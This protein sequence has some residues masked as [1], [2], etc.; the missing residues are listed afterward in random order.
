MEY[1]RSVGKVIEGQL[2][3]TIRR[4]GQEMD[5]H[6]SNGDSEAAQQSVLMAAEAIN[7]SRAIVGHFESIQAQLAQ[8][9]LVLDPVVTHQAVANRLG[10]ADS[11]AS[12]THLPVT[13][14]N[15]YIPTKSVAPASNLSTQNQ[16]LDE[17]ATSGIS[18]AFNKTSVTDPQV[19]SDP[20]I[21]DM[22]ERVIPAGVRRAEIE[23]SRV[24]GDIGRVRALL[25]AESLAINPDSS[26]YL[27][28]RI[29]DILK[30]MYHEEL[31]SADPKLI[32]KLRPR[33]YVTRPLAVKDL[34][35]FLQEPFD[36]ELK[37]AA[38][39]VKWIR[40]QPE[41][42]S[43]SV[44]EFEE[45]FKRNI[46]FQEVARIARSRQASGS[47]GNTTG[48][49]DEQKAGV[50]FGDE[51]IDD[52]EQTPPAPRRP[53]VY[54]DRDGRTFIAERGDMAKVQSSV[55]AELLAINGI[56][57][58][59]LHESVRDAVVASVRERLVGEDES[60]VKSEIETTVLQLYNIRA[61]GL[62]KLRNWEKM[63]VAAPRYARTIWAWIREQPEYK[64]LS[65]DELKQ[66]LTRE[67]SY[68]DLRRRLEADKI[69]KASVSHTQLGLLVREASVNEP[70]GVLEAV[71][72][73]ELNIP[74]F[75]G[76]H[77][78][79]IA[80]ALRTNKSTLDSFGLKLND[81]DET[82][83]Q[84][85]MTEFLSDSQLSTNLPEAAEQLPE[86]MRAFYKDPEAVYSAI[87]NSDADTSAQAYAV[88]NLLADV[89]QDKVEDFI[90]KVFA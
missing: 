69:E 64:G 30:A 55:I 14:L 67:T 42:A 80:I 51:K 26:D 84:E 47:D 71:P 22:S 77:L 79:G 85:L 46:S 36:E 48:N 56:G 6:Y 15:D 35:W 86:M 5:T 19:V 23:E 20:E 49:I 2:S 72:E 52:K 87:S 59:Y 1:L 58:G 57:T 29:D 33:F 68:D 7:V 81:T 27:Y 28:P 83:L 9:G 75:E 45:I 24:N 4:H 66:V 39:L 74:S 53:D 21:P 41:Y 37:R 11:L 73:I 78:L 62:D 76:R 44:A 32:G 38:T 90:T 54:F 40:Q 65:V 25:I 63:P 18:N 12:Q 17:L 60:R 89:D 50:L 3:D 13:M 61:G 88:L 16:D 43:L 34:E 8:V 70:S 10:L 82:A 31:N